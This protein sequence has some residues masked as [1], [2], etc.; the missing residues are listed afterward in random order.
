MLKDRGLIKQNVFTCVMFGAILSFVI[1]QSIFCSTDMSVLAFIIAIPTF[2]LSILK[3]TV[4]ILEDLNDRITSYLQQIENRG[5]YDWELLDRI[6]KNDNGDI[7]SIVEEFFSENSDYERRCEELHSYYNSRKTRELIR[8][9]RRGV[10]YIYY[11]IFMIM[12]VLL[13]LHSELSVWIQG[14]IGNVID[15]N[16]FTIWSLIIV[17]LEIMMK[18]IFEDI[19]FLYLEKKTG[20]DLQWY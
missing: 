8:K 17:L 5:S 1:Y 18:S 13:L 14:S 20:I 2:V 4:D 12:F 15:L 19:L 9:I 16:L 6:R 3:L 11:L 10:L 7:S